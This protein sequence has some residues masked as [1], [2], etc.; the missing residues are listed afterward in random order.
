M[1]VIFWE[2]PFLNNLFLLNDHS[3]M[4]NKYDPGFDRKCCSQELSF[5][6]AYAIR[7]NTMIFDSRNPALL[8]Q[9]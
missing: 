5:L 3:G 4:K 6:I 7:K 8:R 2:I 9:H 1:V